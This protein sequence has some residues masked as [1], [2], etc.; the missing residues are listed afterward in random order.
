MQFDLLK[1]DDIDKNGMYLDF[2][3]VYNWGV[4]DSKVYTM[5]CGKKATLLTGLNGSGKTTLVDAFLSL[6]VPPRQRFYNQSAGAES[7]RERDEISYVLGTYGNKREE[8]FTSGTANNLR[9]KENCIS[10]L[11]GCFVLGDDQRPITLMQVRFFS[12]GGALQKIYS[13][14]HARLSIE[15]IQKAGIDFTPQSN[16]KKTHDRTIRHQVLRR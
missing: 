7:K 13:I 2:F 11:L 3:Q 16:W 4:F 6:I 5:R 8:E 15:E 1:T 9:T 12:G 10:I 14:T